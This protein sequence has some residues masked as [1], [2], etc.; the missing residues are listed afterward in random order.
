MRADT[1]NNWY[2]QGGV[3]IM[4]YDMF[5]NL[6][7]ENLEIEGELKHTFQQSLVDPG[8]DLVVCDEGHIIKG[9]KTYLHSAM[10][11][12]RTMRRIMLTGTPLQNNLDEYYTMV[13][14][15]KPSLFGTRKEFRNRFVNPIANGQYPNS[16]PA[17]IQEMKRRSHVLYTLLE[18]CVQ[19]MD[20]LILKPYLPPK[21]ESVVYIRLS[22]LQI[23]LYRVSPLTNTIKNFIFRI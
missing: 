13:N 7:N 16:T 5:T 11:R 2:K 3:L 6:S 21:E 8:A 22:E 12:I 20:Y 19:R 9:E 14:F 23:N 10:S 18:G 4:G 15:I 17:D 1:F